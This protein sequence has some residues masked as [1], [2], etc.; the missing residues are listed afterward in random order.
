MKSEAFCPLATF[1][2][3]TKYPKLKHF[4]MKVS[5][6]IIFLKYITTATCIL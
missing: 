1:S 6:T 4:Y 2:W 5:V 3:L